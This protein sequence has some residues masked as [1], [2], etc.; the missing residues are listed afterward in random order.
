MATL[1][2]LVLTPDP[3]S[4]CLLPDALSSGGSRLIGDH[5]GT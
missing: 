3:A 2:A 5:G 4:L 1:S